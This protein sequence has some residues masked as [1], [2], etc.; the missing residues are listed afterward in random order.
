MVSRSSWQ[1][2][3]GKLPHESWGMASVALPHGT[4][5]H[6]KSKSN[7]CGSWFI[8]FFPE[9]CTMSLSASSFEL[10]SEALREVACPGDRQFFLQGWHRLAWS[11]APSLALA[12]SEGR[13]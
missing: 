3:S 2:F 5:R 7:L 13:S 10:P 8:L 4:A 12:Q 11:S 9:S 6:R 1:L